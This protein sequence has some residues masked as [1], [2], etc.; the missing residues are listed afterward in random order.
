MFTH[1]AGAVAL[2]HATTT[3]T[4]DGSTG[5]VCLT[6]ARVSDGPWCRHTWWYW[7]AQAG[8]LLVTWWP[9]VVAVLVTAAVLAVVVRVRL[10][11]SRRVR[12]SGARW[13]EIVC[14]PAPARSGAETFWRLLAR[15]S[16]RGTRRPVVGLEA[17][18]AADGLHLGLWLPPGVSATQVAAAARQA[19]PGAQ[20][21]D[22]VAAPWPAEGLRCKEMGLR[23]AEHEA[24]PLAMP[25]PTEVRGA[26]AERADLDDPLR[27]V[28]QCLAE[29][30]TGVMVQVLVRRA[31]RRRLRRAHAVQWAAA[32]GRRPG[33]GSPVG[34]VLDGLMTV[35]L[36]VLRAVL[37]LVTPGPSTP[38]STGGYPSMPDQTVV[39]AS[40]AMRAKLAAFPHFEVA[41]TVAAAGGRREAAAGTA[42]QVADAF[43]LSDADNRLVAGRV[44][45][46][47]RAV[48]LRWP[49]RGAWFLV[50]APELAGLAHLPYAPARH[51]IPT[52]AGRR[53]APPR[54]LHDDHDDDA[55]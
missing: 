20:V 54:D 4:F 18:A 23:L 53:V 50:C 19:W 17:V 5:R 29:A 25:A 15:L 32:A 38:P 48:G 1:T 36:G 10:W 34:R 35:V 51:A 52:V 33:G 7:P 26:D 46:P 9:A 45:R 14:P 2:A 21:Q 8:H 16:A 42:K 31:R 30:D 24:L 37:D 11:R 27:I 12:A 40:Q 49:A 39:A 22:P 43:T 41:V 55:A 47:G 28:W 6:R 13:L 3:R 44:H